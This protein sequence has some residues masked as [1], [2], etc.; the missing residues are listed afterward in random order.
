[1]Q[2]VVRKA[3]IITA[4]LH[5][6]VGL[7]LLSVYEAKLQTG[8]WEAVRTGTGNGGVLLSIGLISFG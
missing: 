8:H 1:M 4:P 2:L 3:Q 5:C 6:N 7:I